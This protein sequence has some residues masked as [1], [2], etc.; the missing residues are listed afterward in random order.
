[1]KSIT[2]K[3]IILVIMLSGGLLY[4]QNDVEKTGRKREKRS[5]EE[6]KNSHKNLSADSLIEKIGNRSKKRLEKLQKRLAQLPERLEKMQERVSKI[7]RKGRRNGQD[8]ECKGDCENSSNRSVKIREK[9]N[10]RYENF[11][12]MIS[13]RKETFEK[14]KALRRENVDKRIKSLSAEDKERVIEAFEKSDAEMKAEIDK[15][16]TETMQ[17]VEE[18]YRKALAS[19]ESQNSKTGK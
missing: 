15:I 17:K 2:N 4:A 7:A 12:K 14:N 6:K 1:M 3:I 19:L 13:K 16:T 11:K 8:K 18:A 5:L 9:L 10:E